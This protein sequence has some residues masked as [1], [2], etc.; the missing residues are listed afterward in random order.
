MIIVDEDTDGAVFFIIHV[1]DL[2]VIGLHV[3]GELALLD[4]VHETF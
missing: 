1:L 3:D 4:E 2:D